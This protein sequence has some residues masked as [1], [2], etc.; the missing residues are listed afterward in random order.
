VAHHEATKK[1]TG[2]TDRRCQATTGHHR[3]EPL[4]GIQCPEGYR[5]EL[6]AGAAASGLP[7]LPRKDGGRRQRP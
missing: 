6:T 2:V 1:A 3:D 4:N 7:K 5:R